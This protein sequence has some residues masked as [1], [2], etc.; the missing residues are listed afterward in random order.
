MHFNEARPMSDAANLYEVLFRQEGSSYH[1]LYIW[2][3]C[4]SD[5]DYS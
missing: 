1:F 2:T 5:Y 3:I 4:L